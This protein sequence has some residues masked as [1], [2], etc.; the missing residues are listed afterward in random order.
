MAQREVARMKGET[1][2]WFAVQAKPASEALAESNLRSLHVETLYPRVQKAVRR[3]GRS[4]R[5]VKRPFFPGYLFAR[6]AP[7]ESLRA[8]TYSRGVTRVLGTKSKP[9]PVEDAII[10]G[11]RERMDECGCVALEA[12]ALKAGDAVDILEGPFCGW[13]G[14]FERDLSD[15]QRVVILLQALEQCRLVVHRDWVERTES[16]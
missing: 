13:S 16:A 14:V 2:H 10:D 6:F 8:V 11:I 5:M 7:E 15:G 1:L 4:S 9:L 3:R 12:H